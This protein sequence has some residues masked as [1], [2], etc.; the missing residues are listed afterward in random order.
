VI[1]FC[2][3]A[4][5]ISVSNSNLQD[6]TLP[7]N[8]ICIQHIGRDATRRAG[9]SVLGNSR[10]S[11]EFTSLVIERHAAILMV[12]ITHWVSCIMAATDSLRMSALL[13]S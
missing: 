7:P 11:L 2:S 3:Q 12:V 4:A 1:K 5:N 13:N 8:G 10:V 6:G 9:L